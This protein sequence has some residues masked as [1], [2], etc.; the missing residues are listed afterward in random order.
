MATC[1][2]QLRNALL[3]GMCMKDGNAQMDTQGHG[4]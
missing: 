1:D 2:V 3:D 4:K